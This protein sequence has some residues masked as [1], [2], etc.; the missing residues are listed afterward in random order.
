VEVEV[1]NL[2][3]EAV[4]VIPHSAQL[5][6]SQTC[7]V[8]LQSVVYV[9]KLPLRGAHGSVIRPMQ[10]MNNHGLIKFMKQ[11]AMK[12][13]TWG[14]K[15]KGAGRKPKGEK[16][17]VPHQRRPE[18]PVRHPV[19]VTLRLLSGVGFLRAF[20]R[21]RA[22]EDALR[23]ARERFGMRVVHY[24]IQGQHL[25]LIVEADEPS[26]LSRAIQGLCV[27]LARALN[28]LARRAGKVFSD[29]FHSHVLE[30]PRKVANAVRYVLENFRHHLREDVAPRGVD[31]C[32]SAGWGDDRPG[33]DPPF[34]PPRTWLLQRAA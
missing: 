5:V 34:S 28:R 13:P 3:H 12:L 19:H 15:R 21:K 33:V 29:R 27:R 11:L 26:A 30:T 20:S 32:S 17:G 23:A 18:F 31:P 22:I 8:E 9:Q 16:A 6:V 7:R 4:I 14:G 10:V 1:L 2:G 25:H 24:S